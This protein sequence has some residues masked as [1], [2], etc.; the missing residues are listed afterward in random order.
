MEGGAPQRPRPEDCVG[1]ADHEDVE[2]LA[3]C[4]LPPLLLLPLPFLLGPRRARVVDPAAAGDP[5]V[6]PAVGPQGEVEEGAG[7][8]SVVQV[9]GV[10]PAPL[11]R[12]RP[13]LPLGQIAQGPGRWGRIQRRSSLLS[14]QVVYLP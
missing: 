8:F 10:G 9:V 14:L 12:R 5:A 13:V 11:Q 7:D 6:P 4:G 1:V 3:V 2:E